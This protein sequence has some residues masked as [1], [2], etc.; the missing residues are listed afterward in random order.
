MTPNFF[1]ILLVAAD[2]DFPSFQLIKIPKIVKIDV[3]YFKACSL[4]TAT[5]KSWKKQAKLVTR[6]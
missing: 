1:L 6:L 4:L 5:S 3:F 2:E